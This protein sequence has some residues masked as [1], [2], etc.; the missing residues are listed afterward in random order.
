[1]TDHM[2]D[3]LSA[4]GRDLRAYTV[5]ALLRTGLTQTIEAE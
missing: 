5:S 3:D 4:A 1:M 2:P